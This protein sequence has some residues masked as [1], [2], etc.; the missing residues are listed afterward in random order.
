MHFSQLY[1]LN[2]RIQTIFT[3]ILYKEHLVGKDK[4]NQSN[5]GILSKK[6]SEWLFLAMF[7]KIFHEGHFIVI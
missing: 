1:L 4:L 7:S 5:H 3:F 6:I 2:V